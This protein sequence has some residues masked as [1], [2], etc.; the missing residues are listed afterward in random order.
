[1]SP[2]LTELRDGGL[3]TGEGLSYLEA[4]HLLL[5]SYCSHIVF[6]LLLKAEGRPVRDHPV[7]ARWVGV[8]R[9][10]GRGPAWREGER[11]EREGKD[12][13]GR[14]MEE[15]R[16]EAERERERRGALWW[17]CGIKGPRRLHAIGD[18]GMAA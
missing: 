5:L 6:Y 1:M 9:V 17:R 10:G 7:I 15:G 16:G 12:R 3:A 2:L 14:S 11:E 8:R 13:K 4:K 18:Q